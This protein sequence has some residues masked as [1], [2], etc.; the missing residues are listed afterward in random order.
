M[1]DDLVGLVQEPVSQIADYR[2]REIRYSLSDCI[3]SGFAM[4]SLKDPSLLSFMDNYAARRENLEQIYKIQDVPSDQGLRKILDPLSPKVFV[5]TFSTVLSQPSTQ[6]LLQERYTCLTSLGGYLPIAADSTAQYDSNTC[7]CSNCMIKTFKNGQRQYYHQLATVCIVH[8]DRKNVF[9]VY[10]EPITRQ[11]GSTENDCEYNAFKRLLPKVDKILPHQRKLIL[12]DGLFAS[13]PVI[14][15]MQFYQMEFITVVKEGYVLVQADRLDQQ[16]KFNS[17]TWYKD[18]HTKCKVKWT[19]DLILNG[20]NQD[21]TVSYLAYE[22]VDTRTAKTIYFNKWITSFTLS[23]FILKEVV[24]IARARWKI[25]SETFNTLK[26]H[27][28]HL[29]HNYGH[30][31]QFLCSVFA[32]LMFLAFLVDQL[33]QV[34]DPFLQ[35]AIKATKTLRDF[36]QKSESFLILFPLCQ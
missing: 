17:K 1:F 6:S 30:G 24:K 4:L 32:I 12:L 28:Y 8:P 34:L 14:R 29:E 23:D 33:A 20:A 13:G 11:D 7:Q 25:E 19:K 10:A 5:D 36:R 27:G 18:K 22:E 2:T 3:M 26:N 35:K 9:G 31:K 21:L 15:A 16:G